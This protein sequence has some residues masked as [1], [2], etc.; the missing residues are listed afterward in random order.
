MTH[1]CFVTL[2]FFN[3]VHSDDA[4][5]LKIVPG[6]MI[7][8]SSE[9]TLN[10]KCF[11]NI[12]YC[13]CICY[14]FSCRCMEIRMDCFQIHSRKSVATLT[15]LETFSTSSHEVFL[16]LLQ[17][18]LIEPLSNLCV[19]ITMSIKQYISVVLLLPPI[20]I[21]KQTYCKSGNFHNSQ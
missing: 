14:T 2:H 17:V 9:C 6:A 11:I 19:H 8:A 12:T 5:M 1:F 20:R 4:I 7:I 21:G 15:R 10:K 13:V 16:Y 3:V 18:T